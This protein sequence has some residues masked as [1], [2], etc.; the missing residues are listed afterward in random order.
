MP[1]ARSAPCWAEVAEL[2]RH[3]PADLVE[4]APGSSQRERLHIAVVIPPFSRGSGGHNSIFQ[5]LLRLE[6]FGHTCSIWLYDPLGRQSGEW[7]S[8][9]RRRVVDEFAPVSA[10]FFKGFEEWF[11]ADVVVATG[12]ETTY[13]VMRLPGCRARAYLVH[14]HESEFFATSA[15]S[16]WAEQTYSF[17][18]YPIS[19]STWL[20]DL[21]EERYGR[22][23]SWFRFG[24][25][26]DVYRQLPVERRRD[27]V[28]FYS[29]DATPRRAVPL[30]LLA[31]DELWRRR[32]DV[33][34]VLFGDP[35]PAETT[36][37]HEHLGVVDPQTLA[38]RYREATV[39]VCLSLTNYSLIPQEM[40]ACGLPCVDVSGGSTEVELGHDAGVEYG[41]PDPVA[42]ADAME[43]LITDEARWNRRS[44]AG[45]ALAETA[46]WDVAARQVERGLRQ[47]LRER[48]A[49]VVPGG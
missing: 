44:H 20:R 33:R 48:E 46:S 17:D 26:H 47:A 43:A 36:F 2:S 22:R 13:P 30:G 19:G 4:P 24:V 16:L 21:L 3:G 10:P 41:E 34:I 9:L 11:G 6:R 14:D 31:L 39:G 38:E 12:W 23:G 27:T 37:Q 28:L 42:L 15:E 8:V 25:D 1:P 7:P 32:P 35:K 5:M 49:S 40:M 45:L 18:L 29:R